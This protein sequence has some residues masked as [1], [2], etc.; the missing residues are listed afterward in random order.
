MYVNTGGKLAL[1]GNTLTLSGIWQH[2][3][4]FDAGMG[5][6][7]FAGASGQ[8][9]YGANNPFHFYNLTVANSGGGSLAIQ[10]KLPLYVDGTLNLAGRNLVAPS[11]LYLSGNW[12]V[13][14]GFDRYYG[15][16]HFIGNTIVS[17]NV[18]LNLQDVVIEAGGTFTASAPPTL[19]VSGNWTNDG[20]FIHNGGSVHFNYWTLIWAPTPPCSIMS[21]WLR[22]P[23]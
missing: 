9:L 22:T 7:V 13:N 8:S 23:S 20:T 1:N 12:I 16:V 10:T 19:S 3:G 5:T 17:G 11:N 2:Y 4:T 15:K 18:A 14:G 6:V 21:R